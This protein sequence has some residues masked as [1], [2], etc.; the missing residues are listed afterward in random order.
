MNLH[1]YS[2]VLVTGGA[3][4]LGSHVTAALLAEGISVC[5]LDNFS[6]GKWLHLEAVKDDPRLTV[7]EGDVTRREDVQRAIHGCE[8]VIHL[9]VLGLRESIQ[10]PQRVSDVVING[11]LSCLDAARE[12]G[13][14]LFLNCS[15]SEVY[16]TAQTVPMSESHPLNPETPYA[17]AKVAQDA[18]VASYGRTYGLPWVT[19]R[20]FNMYGPHSHWA[21]ARGELI[22][23]M[24][25]RAMNR[26]PLLVF[27]DGSQTRDFTYVADAARGMLAV[28]GCPARSQAINVCSGVETS[29]RTIAE[30]I[31]AEFDLD[32]AVFIEYQEGRPGDV[33]RH[34]GD[35]ETLRRLTG[36]VPQVDVHTGIAQT[37]AWFR[38]LPFAPEDMLRGEVARNWT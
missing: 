21:G 24:I 12:Q 8:A 15:S 34:W 30:S 37:V 16:G 1:E 2:R 26:Q 32:P 23:K 25:V 20:P 29:V 27:G 33:R 18:F 13:V 6:N 35:N 28:L 14:K 7:I 31:C 19:V 10:D 3:G 22:P 17:A 36:F 4:F 5:V 9:S 38:S 11:T